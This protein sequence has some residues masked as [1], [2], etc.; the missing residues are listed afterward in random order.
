MFVPKSIGGITVVVPFVFIEVGNAD[1][2]S[3]QFSPP[4]SLFFIKFVVIKFKKKKK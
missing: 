4:F 2:R 1:L 3:L